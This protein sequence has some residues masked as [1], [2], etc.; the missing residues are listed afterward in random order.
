MVLSRI[1]RLLAAS[2][3]LFCGFAGM[4]AA[5]PLPPHTTTLAEIQA[6]STLR[7]CIWPDY[8]SISF[9]NPRNGQL[10]GIDIDLARMLAERLG[11]RVEFID[12]NF[13]EF[14]GRLE[15]RDCDIAMFGVGITPARAARIAFSQPY[16]ISRVYAVTRRDGGS[17]ARWDDIDQPGNVVAVAAGTLM[18]PLMRQTL[19]QAEMLVVRP[20]NSREAELQSGRADV[21][22]SDY[23]YTR[24]MM[25]MHDWMRIIDPPGPFG[26]TS[27]GFAMAPGDAAWLAEVNAFL[28]AVRADGRLAAAAERAGL[29]PIVSR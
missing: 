10:E 4:A 25:V 16:L 29:S 1:R 19:R 3:C 27:Y 24:R 12:T 15:R 18:E 22:M 14:I 21:F 23:P 20:P 2:L 8:Y 17:I 13:A 5:Q 7:V 28:D 26:E 11:R 9:R 6:R